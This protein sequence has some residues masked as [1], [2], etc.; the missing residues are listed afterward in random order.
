MRTLLLAIGA[1]RVSDAKDV[2]FLTVTMETQSVKIGCFLYS[3]HIVHEWHVI[4]HVGDALRTV[5]IFERGDTAMEKVALYAAVLGMLE[6]GNG[7]YA[8]IDRVAGIVVH[9]REVEFPDAK[10]D[11]LCAQP[12]WW[13]NMLFRA[14]DGHIVQFGLGKSDIFSVETQRVEEYERILEKLRAPRAP[15]SET[16]A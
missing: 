14:S 16:P 8:H 15:H 11:Y 5:A 10:I 1:L 4:A 3:E 6:V 12:I 7:L 13:T 9:N 2:T